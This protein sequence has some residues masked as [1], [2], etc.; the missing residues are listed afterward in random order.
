MDHTHSFRQIQGFLDRK[1]GL[2]HIR[3]RTWGKSIVLYS[4]QDP[5][6]DE[7]ARLTSAS[8]RIWQLSLPKYNG[9]WER[10]PFAGGLDDVLAV[11]VDQFGFWLAER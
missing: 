7:H 9:G 5:D 4:G 10:T 1:G 2:G 6:R 8:P 11:L 3:L